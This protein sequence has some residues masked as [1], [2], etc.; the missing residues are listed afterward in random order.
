[1]KKC[2]GIL[3]LA[4]A[5]FLSGCKA[6]EAGGW[7][8]PAPQKS[9]YLKTT[10]GGFVGKLPLPAKKKDLAFSCSY[11]ANVSPQLPRPAYAKIIFEMPEKGRNH[12]ETILIGENDTSLSGSSPESKNWKHYQ[13]YRVE[14][15]VFSDKNMT[16]K[17]DR[18][19]QFIRFQMPRL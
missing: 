12:E 15:L 9:K 4:S 3:L 11:G 1:M 10:D 19:E 6:M 7:I 18:L 16:H 5:T 14:V 13:G 8:T 2:I 17:I